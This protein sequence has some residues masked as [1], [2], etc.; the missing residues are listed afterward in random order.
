[1]SITTCVNEADG[2]FGDLSVRQV[3][4]AVIAT[5]EYEVAGICALQSD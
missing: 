1:M 2:R 3:E 4:I 5:P